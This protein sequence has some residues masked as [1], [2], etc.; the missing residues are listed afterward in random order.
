MQPFIECQGKIAQRKINGLEK[1]R[2]HRPT[3]H[4]DKRKEFLTQQDTYHPRSKNPNHNHNGKR[5]EEHNA[6]LANH[7]NPSAFNIIVSYSR[8][9]GK[10][11][12]GYTRKDHTRIGEST[13]IASFE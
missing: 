4:R 8:E 12:V 7:H 13:L 6:N 2:Q 9:S 3:H 11:I 1:N 10:I 5:D